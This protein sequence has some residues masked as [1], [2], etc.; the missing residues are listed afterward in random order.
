MRPLHGLMA[1]FLLS[2]VAL[3]A[4]ARGYVSDSPNLKLYDHDLFSM[5]VI[6]LPLAFRL[7]QHVARRVRKGGSLKKAIWGANI[8]PYIPLCAVAFLILS[9]LPWALSVSGEAIVVVLSLAGF[10]LLTLDTF[11]SPVD[12]GQFGPRWVLSSLIALPS[13][14]W[15][16]TPILGDITREVDRDPELGM[17]YLAINS[18]MLTILIVWVFGPEAAI[19]MATLVAPLALLRVTLLTSGKF[20]G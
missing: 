13:K 8:L 9:P 6:A 10:V 4:V 11:P 1:L 12:P 3:W 20:R 19:L 14:L 16:A 17:A 15:R 2:P 7:I 18:L 5:G